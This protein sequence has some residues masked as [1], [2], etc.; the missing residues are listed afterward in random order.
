MEKR[1]QYTH[2]Y[3]LK[4]QKFVLRRV[5]EEEEKFAKKKL[6]IRQWFEEG[7]S[8]IERMSVQILFNKTRSL[9]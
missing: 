5:D 6:K 8:E 9:P 3:K 2:V 7:V 1:V 4:N